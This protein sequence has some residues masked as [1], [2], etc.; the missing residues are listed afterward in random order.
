MKHMHPVIWSKGT[1]LTPQHLQTQ[2]MYFESTLRFRLDA[3]ATFSYGITS[4]GLDLSSLAAGEIAVT[5]ASGIMPD[6]LLFDMPDSD[7]PPTPRNIAKFFGK[8]TRSIDVFLSIPQY[9]Y[10]G[11]N[12][13]ANSEATGTRYGSEIQLIRDENTGSSE[14]PVQ[15]ARKNFSFLFEGEKSEG[16]STLRIA[17]VRPQDGA[18]VFDPVFAPPLLNCAANEYVFGIARRLTETL[19]SRSRELAETRRQK[20]VTQADF[21]ASDI[22]NFWLLYTVN[23]FLPLV[24]HVLETRQGHP[25]PFFSTLLSLAASLTTFSSSVQPRDLPVYNHEDLSECFSKLEE[26][27]RFLLEAAPPNFVSLVLKKGNRS[28]FSTQLDD[29]KLLV[30]T[31]F[32]LAIS[33]EMNKADLIR[34]G[35]LLLKA[36]STNQIEEIVQRALPGLTLTSARPGSIPV[37]LNHQYF[38]LG[39]TGPI[40]ESL[41]RSRSFSVYVPAEIPEPQIELIV[42]LPSKS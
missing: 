5:H 31:K 23:S 28:F 13:S 12:V 8:D 41:V 27:L 34:K 3:L 20:S 15:L 37:K 39:Q 7:R 26:K 30:N 22:E 16:N 29:D 17:R 18:F 40:W 38:A 9:R 1:F 32:Y 36:C 25:E 19:S 35:P 14:K 10:R 42:V 4:F 6:G 24:R 21:T 11:L 2:D 33:S